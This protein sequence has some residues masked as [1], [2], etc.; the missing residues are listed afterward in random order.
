MS[1]RDQLIDE[2]MLGPE[3]TYNILA[4][5][6]DG[7]FRFYTF[8]DESVQTDY[9][10]YLTG[11]MGELGIVRLVFGESALDCVDSDDWLFTLH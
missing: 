10:D 5:F 4:I 8:S 7:N 1:F 6:G 9:I 11:R 3:V 2:M